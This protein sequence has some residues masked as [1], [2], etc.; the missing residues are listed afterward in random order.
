MNVPGGRALLNLLL[1]A[2]GWVVLVLG[3]LAL[4]LPGPGLL[5]MFA[6]LAILSKYNAWAHRWVE[7]VRLRALRGA[8]ES[9]ETIPRIVLSVL[10]VLGLFA[11]GVLWIVEPPA[12]QWW[13]LDDF[14]WL[15]GGPVTGVT[16][17]VSGVVAGA[18]IGYS[19]RRFH[20]KPE[21]VAELEGDI[22]EADDELPWHEEEHR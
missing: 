21:A 17:I 12:P 4:F 9:V 13:P 22:E 20:G 19:Y 2:V 10:G 6:G 18:L 8:A 5:M 1:Q 16:L 11:C 15:V 14:W 3:V 7:P